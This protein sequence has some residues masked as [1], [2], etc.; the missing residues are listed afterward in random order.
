MFHVEHFRVLD[1]FMSNGN[2]GPGVRQMIENQAVERAAECPHC[3]WQ[4]VVFRKADGTPYAVE[5]GNEE[6]E[7]R[8]MGPGCVVRWNRRYCRGR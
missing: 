3:G 6:C 5:C 7:A 2:E 1:T 4:A 8:I